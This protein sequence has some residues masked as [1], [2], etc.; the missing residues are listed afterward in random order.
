MSQNNLYDLG[1]KAH[2]R[3]NSKL[4][5]GIPMG[6]IVLVQGEYGGGKSAMAQRFCYGLC[7]S[8]Y[9][10]TFLS[11][12][13]STRKFLDQ[14][15]SLSY[16]VSEYLLGEQLLFLHADFDSTGLTAP[17]SGNRNYLERLM[18]AKTMWE[19]NVIIIDTFDSILRNDSNFEALVRNDDGRQTALEI[20]SFFRNIIEKGKSIVLTV[21]HTTLDEETLSPFRAVAD[22]LLELEMIEVANDVRRQMNVKRFAGMGN[23]VGNVIGFGVQSDVGIVIENREVT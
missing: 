11:T 16:D 8:G 5:G 18:A 2:D 20:I 21:D 12:E 10:V 22:V 23:Q 14:M 9:S 17:E 4:G 15:H 6:S 19:P 7:E 13:L 3:V 1:L